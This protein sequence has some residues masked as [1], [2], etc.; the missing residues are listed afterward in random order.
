MDIQFLRDTVRT[1][2]KAK[3]LSLD[4]LAEESGI[5][6][7]TIQQF[8][9]GKRTITLYCL[10]E[11]LQALGLQLSIIE[12]TRRGNGAIKSRTSNT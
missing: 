4:R 2:R 5:S 8:E 10:A 7:I 11:I 6:W 9:T 12:E 3:G 1:T